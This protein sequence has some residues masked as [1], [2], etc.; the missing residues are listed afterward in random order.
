LAR[1]PKANSNL[2]N[3]REPTIRRIALGA[4]NFDYKNPRI[5]W[6]TIK[7]GD[8]TSMVAALA[9]EAD[10]QELVTAI[11]TQGFLPFDEMIATEE[12]K[13]SGKYVV[14]EGYRRLAALKILTDP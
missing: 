1:A 6:V 5:P 10:V 4:L 12:P 11:G 9:R 7:T 13:N 14:L 3:N 8:E 2:S